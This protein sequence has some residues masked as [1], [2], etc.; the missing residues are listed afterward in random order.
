MYTKLELAKKY[1]HYYLTASNGKGHGMHSPFVFDFIINV[2]NVK[3]KIATIEQLR[4]QLLQKNTTLHIDDF[5][6]GSTTKATN[7][8]TIAS[9]AKNAAKPK[10]YAQVLHNIAKYYQCNTIIELGT[11]LGISSAYLANANPFATIYT[12]EG[13]KEI[14]AIAKQNFAKLFLKNIKVIEG[15]FSKSYN[16]VLENINTI[17]FLYIDGNHQMEPTLHYFQQAI[18]KLHN[19]SIIVFDDIHWSIGMEAAWEKIKTMDVVS[20]TIDLFFIGIVFVRKEQKVKQ[21]FTV[22][23]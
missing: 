7:Q 1:L 20:E 2:L 9:I 5:G 23:F 15:E 4:N 6:A 22:R 18:P 11:S 17:D 13:S 8:R 10:K 14:A 21:H 19:D 12:C 16:T 3:T